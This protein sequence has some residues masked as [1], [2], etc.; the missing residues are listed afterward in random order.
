MKKEKVRYLKGISLIEWPD[1]SIDKENLEG[2]LDEIT[3]KNINNSIRIRVYKEQRV[4]NFDPDDPEWE[5][6][7]FSRTV[8]G[9]KRLYYQVNGKSYSYE[10]GPSI[11]TIMA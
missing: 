1:G 8:M 11:E 6:V 10:K 4:K 5:S 2:L 9:L 3:F 7:P